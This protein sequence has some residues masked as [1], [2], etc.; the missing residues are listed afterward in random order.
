VQRLGNPNL[1]TPL[2]YKALIKL[3]RQSLFTEA[4][5]EELKLSAGMQVVAEIH[6]GR[7]TVFEYLTSP[8]QKVAKEAGRER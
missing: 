6:Q 1:Q 8:V 3:G 2:T 5:K 4:S 7:R